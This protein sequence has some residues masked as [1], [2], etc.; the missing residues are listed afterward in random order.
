M[1]KIGE[2][3]R[4]QV[5][6]TY[7]PGAIID[8]RTANN[9]LISAVVGGLEEWDSCAPGEGSQGCGHAQSIAEP[10]LQ[11]RLRIHGF[12]LPPVLPP[13]GDGKH[14]AKFLEN[15][16]D[17]PP[18]ARFP[19]WLQCPSCGRLAP[20]GEWQSEFEFAPERWCPNDACCDGGSR[21]YAVPVRFIVACEDGHLQEFPWQA[22]AGCE[23]ATPALYVETIGPGLAGRIVECRRPGCG[24]SRPMEGAFK[25]GSIRS[26]G[27]RC[28]GHE[29]WLPIPEHSGHK[30]DKEPRVLQ[31]GASNV[32][33]SKV[34]S[35]IAIPPFSSD[36]S[37][38]FGKNWA[39]FKQNDESEWP[40]AI[41]F[42]GMEAKTGLTATEL[43]AMLQRWKSAL[44]DDRLDEP[45]EWAEYLQFQQSV[46][47]ELDEGQ[48]KAR[49]GTIPPEFSHWIDAVSL[50][51]R[52][53]EVRALT[54]FSR[55]HPP[56]GMFRRSEQKLA[57][58]FLKDPGWRPAIDLF[59]EGIF[60]RLRE[61]TLRE[62]ESQ[63][64]VQAHMAALNKR[65]EA[66]L[67]DGDVFEPVSARFVMIHSF[68][69]LLIRQLSLECG[70]SS[71]A[72]RE[73]L[74]AATG[75]H[76]MGGV[77]IMTGSPDAEGTMGG[78]VRQGHEDRLYESVLSALEAA[79]W[80]SSDPV[81][82]TGTMTLSTPLNGAACHACLLLPETCCT[83][84]NAFL[85]RALIV[86]TPEYPELGYFSPLLKE[87]R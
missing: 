76:E 14:R 21:T 58:I 77:L 75:E 72:L 32:Y 10:R 7:G 11:E 33:L 50:V 79:T 71:A 59:G 40:T 57:R 86:G 44:A 39:D 87:Q 54:G 47:R 60:L 31:R 28:R 20:S 29:P 69:H 26:L 61:Q 15:G 35:S 66:T 82:I 80:C 85:D 2:V 12:R 68:A 5:I 24:A 1:S 22:W 16:W 19:H 43:I 45:V 56:S 73:R 25:A 27:H 4:S 34:E 23:C 81:C 3:R 83:Q 63:P 13:E 55:L 62:W 49:P 8:F 9:A 51:Q 17:M 18:V 53:R 41:R 42:L 64:A 46:R 65:V 67:R 78:L 52:L 38:L 37:P 48:F 36:L 6:T 84:F 30:C 70:Y 74:Y